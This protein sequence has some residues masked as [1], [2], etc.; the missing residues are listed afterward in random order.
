[1]WGIGLIDP[2]SRELGMLKA[3]HCHG[4]ADLGILTLINI[5]FSVGQMV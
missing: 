1:M 3:V 2:A 5:D 4:N